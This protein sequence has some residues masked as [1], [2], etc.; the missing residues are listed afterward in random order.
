MWYI[1]LVT[2][3][4]VLSTW[5][6]VNGLYYTLHHKCIREQCVGEKEFKE[7]EIWESRNKTAIN[8]LN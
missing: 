2:Y 4:K 5:C 3:Y 1:V 6:M 8:Y 7:L